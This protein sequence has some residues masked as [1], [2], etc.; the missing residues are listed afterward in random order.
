ME[1]KVRKALM[2][3]LEF[4]VKEIRRIS[5]LGQE[6]AGAIRGKIHRIDCER[7][8]IELEQADVDGK[9]ERKKYTFS[10]ETKIREGDGIISCEYLKEGDW[11]ELVGKPE[12]PEL[13][14]WVGTV[15]LP[16]Q[17]EE[18]TTSRGRVRVHNRPIYPRYVFI[19]MDYNAE[20]RSKISQWLRKTEGVLNL[21]GGW[22]N[23]QPLTDE[24]ISDILRKAGVEPMVAEVDIRPR[25]EVRILGGAFSEFS[26]VVQEVDMGKKRVRVLVN[27]FGRETPVDLPIEQVRKK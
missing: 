10:K 16:V 20:S 1:E 9:T 2:R 7:R 26:G 17:V 6:N 4:Q 15:L 27:L 23:P 24:E 11:V 22:E 3:D 14:K 21:I 18:R 19:E 5:E 25:D 13:K 8:E 12:N